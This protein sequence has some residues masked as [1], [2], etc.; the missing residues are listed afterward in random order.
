MDASAPPGTTAPPPSLLRLF[1]AFM[2]VGLTA[3]GGVL[4]FARRMVVDKN[5]WLDQSA[6]N[7]A[8]SLSQ[9]FPGANVVNLAI[10]VGQRFHGAAGAAAGVIGLLALPSAIVIVL[11][12]LY[13][14]HGQRPEIHGMLQGM[15]AA[16]A[17]LM[18]SS[19]YRMAQPLLNWR[20]WP[21]LVFAAL[22]LIGVALLKWPLPV[23][24][25]VLAPFCLFYE[26][27][28]F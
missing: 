25:L 4:P 2:G 19:V 10:I 8:W 18:L 12:G 13:I 26:W 5:Q 16:A 21:G 3:F 20:S 28:R 14:T 11:G 24:F 9:V 15:A 27:R 1:L 6:F 17:G 23:V 7:R 22:A